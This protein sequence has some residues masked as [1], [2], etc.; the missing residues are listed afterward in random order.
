MQPTNTNLLSRIS[1]TSL[2]LFLFAHSKTHLAS[3]VFV[4]GQL[5][6]W[7]SYISHQKFFVL[8][9]FNRR[10][11]AWGFHLCLCGIFLSESISCYFCNPPLLA[12][13]LV[14]YLSFCSCLPQ[15]LLCETKKKKVTAQSFVFKKPKWTFL[16]TLILRSSHLKDLTNSFLVLLLGPLVVC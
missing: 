7:L 4:R 8:Y 12:F 10:I 2:F 16:T 14:L 11:F 13:F 9:G 6:V 1:T 5:S 3:V 15:F